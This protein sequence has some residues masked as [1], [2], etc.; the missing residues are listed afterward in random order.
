M[1]HL[2]AIV[3]PTGSGKSDLAIALARTFGGEVV[4]ADSRQFI[5]F[6]DIGTAKPTIEDRAGVP[7]HLLDITEPERDL[8]LA[9]Y[10]RLAYQTIDDIQSR[11]R[12]PFLA[13]GSGQYVWAVLEGWHIPGVQPDTVLRA[14]LEERARKEGGEALYRQLRELDTAAADR[15][16]PR[17][18]RRVIRALEIRLSRGPQT[19]RQP[20]KEPP[21]YRILVIGLT[22][23]RPILYR[24]IDLRVDKMIEKGLVEEVR[25]V[26]ARGFPMDAP[27]LNSVGYKEA[28]SHL[29]GELE[30]TEMADRIKA[31]SH[32]LVRHQYNW[33]RL[34][35][36]RIHWLDIETEYVAQA[37]EL[38]G[39]FLKEKSEQNGFY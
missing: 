20:S 14:T 31:E 17:N 8:N 4:S 37:T 5:R 38:V 18:V 3:G 22:A 25:S 13:G 21:P 15:I 19:A 10:Q 34:S 29:K 24:R 9:D 2:I 36:R 33:F 12:L 39:A 7:H 23:D 32:R 1:E 28:I 35:D 16:D 27:G 6:L 26:L 11:S 30:V